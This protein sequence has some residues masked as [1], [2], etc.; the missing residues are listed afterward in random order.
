M[1]QK[2]FLD[3]LGWF[4]LLLSTL[5]M[6]FM[7]PLHVITLLYT[8]LRTTVPPSI[9]EEE[10]SSD[11]VVEER[12]KISLRCRAN[13]YPSPSVVWRREDGKELNLGTVGGKKQSGETNLNAF[14]KLTKRRDE[15][16]SVALSSS[17]EKRNDTQVEETTDGTD[18][19]VTSQQCSSS[20]VCRS[21]LMLS[22]SSHLFFFLSSCLWR[23][24][25]EMMM[26]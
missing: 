20:E 10:T 17:L 16:R 14:E 18:L 21:S 22:S 8:L 1:S 7:D 15:T 24:F 9:I 12:G 13:G 25:E 26:M 3:V 2:G 4:S 23:C 11:I 5:V 19:N 6:S